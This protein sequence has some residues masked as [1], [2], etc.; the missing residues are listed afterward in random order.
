MKSNS[1]PTMPWFDSPRGIITF[2]AVDQDDVDVLA[3]SMLRHF[4]NPLAIGL[5][6]TLG[7]GKTR[8]VQ[9]IAA[10]A[11]VDRVDV[12]SP[13]FTLLQTYQGHRD[14]EQGGAA[15]GGEPLLPGTGSPGALQKNAAIPSARS[16]SHF[17]SSPLTIHHLDAYRIHDE[18]EF[19]ELG[20]DE[21]FDEEAAWTL[22]EWADRFHMA[23]PR[24]TIWVRILIGNDPDR[25]IVQM[26]RPAG[27]EAPLHRVWEMFQNGRSSHPEPS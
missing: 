2:D 7:A 16:L 4:P 6:G 20:V 12:T 21:L 11:H 3:A 13:T 8:F 10:A 18:D 5:I 25:R 15:N 9:A 24:E 17:S 26:A 14:W 23:M 19:L 27:D 1:D 22:V